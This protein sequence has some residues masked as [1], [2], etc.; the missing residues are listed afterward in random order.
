MFL[1][2][3]RKQ[4]ELEMI[5]CQLAVSSKGVMQQ[6]ERSVDWRLWAGTAAQAAAVAMRNEVGGDRVGRRCEL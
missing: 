2:I 5:E 3:D 4:V 1:D 6:L